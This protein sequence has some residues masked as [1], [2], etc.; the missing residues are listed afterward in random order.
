MKDQTAP[1]PSATDLNA[2][3]DDIESPAVD[4]GQSPVDCERLPIEIGLTSIDPGT[5]SIAIAPMLIDLATS[6][7]DISPMSIDPRAMSTDIGAMSVDT[8]SMSN[9]FPA[10]KYLKHTLYVTF[11]KNLALD[12]TFVLTSRRLLKAKP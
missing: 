10:R 5:I 3:I 4:T 2:V 12:G 1:V 9:V 6:S 7:I 8:A 11:A